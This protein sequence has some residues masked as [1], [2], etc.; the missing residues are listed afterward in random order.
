MEVALQV[1]RGG[2]IPLAVFLTDGKANIARDGTAERAAALRD[3]EL[4]ARAMKLAGVR[5]LMID[6]SDARGT[7]ARHIAETM[8]ATYLPLPHADASLISRAVGSA[9][10]A[11]G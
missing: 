9:L 6:M 4:A 8:G 2:G 7:A 3:A 1:R 10:K 5:T 11:G